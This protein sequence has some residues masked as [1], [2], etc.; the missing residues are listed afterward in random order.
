MAGNK[1]IGKTAGVLLSICLILGGG[2]LE[3][4]AG[5]PSGFQVVVLLDISGDS[6]NPRG[7]NPPA[8]RAAALL[9]NL[10]GGQN[11]LGFISSGGQGLTPQPPVRLTPAHR[12]PGPAGP[13]P[14]EEIPDIP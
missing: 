5:E 11:Y 1:R 9:A 3:V 10:L 2:G 6:Y 14:P 7:P 8:F 13:A 4:R 12:R